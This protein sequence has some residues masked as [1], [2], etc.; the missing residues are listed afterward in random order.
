MIGQ[1]FGGSNTA[2]FTIDAE[3]RLTDYMKRAPV[4][5]GEPYISSISAIP[6]LNDVPKDVAVS[7]A[8]SKAYNCGSI[9]ANE[10]LDRYN[11][12]FGAIDAGTKLSSLTDTQYERLYLLHEGLMDESLQSDMAYI[13]RL[14]TGEI[15]PSTIHVHKEQE[16]M[17]SGHSWS[18][19]IRRYRGVIHKE[20][21]VQS[22]KKKLEQEL[23][24]RRETLEK[25]IHH[26]SDEAT[27]LKRIEESQLIANLLLSM[28]H[29][30]LRVH[31]EL[32][33]LSHDGKN[34]T[35]PTQ[36][37]KT[38]AEH[39]EHYF[40]KAKRS[41]ERD[42]E[43]SAKLPIYLQ[44]LQDVMQLQNRFPEIQDRRI[45]EQML[46]Q[47]KAQSGEKASTKNTQ[48]SPYRI[49]ALSE[50]FTLY[51]GRNAK[52]NDQLT[53]KFA[54]PNDLWLHARGVSGSHAV[55]RGPKDIPKHILEQA[56]AITAYFSQSRKAGFVPV[57][58]ALKKYIRKPK[59]AGPG[60]VL[61][62]REEVILIEPTL[63]KGT[64]DV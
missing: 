37:G 26:L 6:S 16:V 33:V 11:E 55:L 17:W 57:A 48:Q 14:K 39:A 40:R 43:K 45:L 62:E 36:K 42:A 30:A 58:Y 23:K 7:V 53:G 31:D 2:L 54:K 27:S 59:G 10:I 21:A 5:I 4:K 25:H 19:A 64:I 22:L 46:L 61:M 18:Q 8:L 50:S 44:Q 49:F 29:P 9:Y 12:A 52:N 3:D 34:Y 28:P 15:I 32:I 47:V 24:Q 60:A 1:F 13:L 56:A 35:I 51:V 63:P 38:Y 20:S 41:K